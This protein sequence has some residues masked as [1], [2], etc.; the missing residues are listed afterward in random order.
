[1]LKFN[2]FLPLINLFIFYFS[3]ANTNI[4]CVSEDALGYPE[5]ICENQEVKTQDCYAYDVVLYARVKDDFWSSGKYNWKYIVTDLITNDTIQFSYNYLPKPTQGVSGD[6]AYDLLDQVK[7]SKI[8]LV[9]PLWIN[10]YKVTWTA[11]DGKGLI[12]S[13][14]QY[15][16]V[17]DKKAPTPLLV[18]FAVIEPDDGI[19]EMQAKS[20][21]KGGCGA[22]CISSFDNCTPQSELYFTFTPVLPKLSENPEIWQAYYEKHGFYSFDPE[23]GDFIIDDFGYELYKAGR[24]HRWW[25]NSNSS[26]K[27][28]SIDNDNGKK[29]RVYVWDQFA[30]N[31]SRNDNNY[32]YAEVLI[33]LKMPWWGPAINGNVPVDLKMT[34][35]AHFE[36]GFFSTVSENGNYTIDVYPNVKYTVSGFS[37]D[38]MMCG[39]STLDLVII[40]KYM[41][42]LKKIHDHYGYIAA[43]AD[44][45]CEIRPNDL[46]TLRKMILN[47]NQFFVHSHVAVNSDYEFKDSIPNL[48]DCMGAKVRIIDVSDE[49]VSGA[50]FNAVRIGDINL[51]CTKFEDRSTGKEYFMVE[52]SD[53]QSGR[54]VVPVYANDFTGVNGFQLTMSMN[55]IE[56]KEIIN[57]E[58]QIEDSE[59]SIRGGHLIMSVARVQ[60]L[61]IEDG[62]VLFFL[63]FDAVTDGTLNESLQINDAILKSEIYKGSNLEISKLELGFNSSEAQL[64]QNVPNPFST[65]TSIGFNLMDDC[66]YEL[67]IYD[68]TGKVFKTINGNGLKGYNSVRIDKEDL[69]GNFNIGI[70]KLKTGNFVY[71][72]K[73]ILMR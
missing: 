40:Q 41:L 13:K 31:E 48:I 19:Y 54:V 36:D 32:S 70:Y 38:D 5:I 30:I 2:F 18:D 10:N 6:K 29:T 33:N 34:M 39:I 43:D 11:W 12:F 21:D 55:G 14:D 68:I 46:L 16:T 26:S 72:K 8:R 49:S 20:L 15:I 59:Y 7:I 50:N 28:F 27:T 47:P 73:M 24:A 66:K 64:Y 61:S 44:G 22:G 35:E 45:D 52:N 63:V 42:G 25:I 4:T 62:K 23:T 1:M 37:D 71:S 3:F 58:I 60:E 67:A 9:V 69:P 17:K 51:D 57:G 56:F 65:Y 53:Y